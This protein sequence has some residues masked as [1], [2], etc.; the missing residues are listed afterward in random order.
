MRKHGVETTKAEQRPCG[1]GLSELLVPHGETLIDK[2]RK[3]LYSL[4]S[5]KT[6]SIPTITTFDTEDFTADLLWIR[7]LFQY[8]RP[9]LES[10]KDSSTRKTARRTSTSRSQRRVHGGDGK[11]YGAPQVTT[12]W[13]HAGQKHGQKHGRFV[14]KRR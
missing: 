9:A 14:Q 7:E 6:P 11:N 12:V 4:V 13:V 3:K 2:D 1:D 5:D 8:L 10:F